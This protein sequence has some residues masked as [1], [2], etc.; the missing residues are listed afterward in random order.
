MVTLVLLYSIN[1][2]IIFATRK[3]VEVW[4]GIDLKLTFTRTVSNELMLLWFDLVSIVE[5]I[6]LSVECDAIIWSL[7][8][9]GLYSVQSLYDVFSFR[10]VMPLHTLALWNINIPPRVHAFLWLL[11]N[12]KLL[13]RDNLEKQEEGGG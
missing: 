9:N 4:D 11:T 1:S 3:T 7:N 8:A 13:A 2:S 12:N 6:E 10:V 5:S